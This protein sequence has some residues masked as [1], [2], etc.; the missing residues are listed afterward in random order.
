M[1]LEIKNYE[2]KKLEVDSKEIELPIKTQY[3]FQTYYRRAIRVKPVYTSWLKDKGGKE[4][5]MHYEVT[6]LYQNFDFNI[7]K[8]KL[9]INDIEEI[10]YDVNHDLYSFVSCWLDGD[11][12]KRTK[13]QF[14]SE[15]KSMVEEL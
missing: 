13:E 8:I 2:Y 15:L 9:G 6:F 10:Y 11:L 1:K 12:N 7:K 3:F 14:D 4:E 5:I